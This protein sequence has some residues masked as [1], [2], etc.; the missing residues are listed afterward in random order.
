MNETKEKQML[1]IGTL[2]KQGEYRVERRIASG[3]F[4]NTYEVVHTRLL[5]HFAVKEFFMRGINQRVGLNVTVSI[6][7][8]QEPFN[9]KRE[10]FYKEA[11]NLALLEEP[12][13][14]EVT[15]FFEENQTAYYVMKLIE[16]ESLAATMKRTGKPFSE[17]EVR[18]ILSQMLPTL[19]VIH[20]QGIF[21]LDLKPSNILRDEKG[22]CWLI[23]FGASKQLYSNESKTLSTSTGLSYS[24]GYAP[25]EQLSGNISRIGAWTDFY[26][27][28]ATIYSLLSNQTPPEPDDV[29]YEGEGA[30]LFPS[31]VSNDMRQ[32]VLWLMQPDYPRRPQKVADITARLNVTPPPVPEPPKPK[33]KGTNGSKATRSSGK[34]RGIKIS[35][36]LIIPLLGCLVLITVFSNIKRFKP[37]LGPTPIPTPTPTPPK[38]TPIDDDQTLYPFEDDNGKYG[39]ID[40]TG[41]VVIPCEWDDANPFFEGLAGVRDSNKK[42]GFINKSGNLVIPCKWDKVERF[43]EGVA[44]VQDNNGKRGFIN[45]KGELVIPCKWKY[46]FRL[47]RGLSC[48]QDDDDKYGYIDKNGKV[49]IPCE[50]NNLGDFHEGLARVEEEYEK[51][52]FID[53]NGEV[54]IP[55]TWLW[56]NDF[57]EGLASV[58]DNNHKCGFIDKTGKVVIPCEWNDAAD[59]SDWLAAVKDS[60]GKWGF[61]DNNGEVVI[62]CEWDDVFD[63]S[64]GLA[65]VK[66]IDEKWGFINKTGKVMIPC[67]WDYA[68]PFFEGL[69]SVRDSNKKWGVINKSGKLVIPCEWDNYIDFDEE[70]LAVVR[71]SNGKMHYIDK[72]GRVVK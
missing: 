26:A 70:G 24:P 30:F 44:C 32:L 52:G 43:T 23:D 60:N 51:W 65:L 50:W 71:D 3:G 56:V 20:N 58:T 54:V 27:L 14:V 31:D 68:N 38:P 34:I 57:S 55:C 37:D 36:S 17:S 2:L 42:W 35:W 16:G 10:K 22:H 67:E 47:D 4:G 15:D 48:V 21:H 49:V 63:F 29:R 11:Q 64:E 6:A 25:T 28:G 39:Y 18:N 5:K 59:F 12:H 69:A 8:N 53:K 72:K 41:K 13:I 66:D 19:E 7:E 33:A 45:R 46:A 62:P 1:P 9:K 61:I 40:K